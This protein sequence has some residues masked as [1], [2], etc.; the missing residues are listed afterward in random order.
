MANKKN[1][2]ITLPKGKYL[3]KKILIK[4]NINTKPNIYQ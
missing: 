1:A 2:K 3:T 4:S